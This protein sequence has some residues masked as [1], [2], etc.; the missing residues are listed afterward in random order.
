MFLHI[1]SLLSHM[2]PVM[3]TKSMQKKQPDP[4]FRI[5]SQNFYFYFINFIFFSG[6]V[7]IR[8]TFS[9]YSIHQIEKQPLT[10]SPLIKNKR[11]RPARV[12]FSYVLY[13]SENPRKSRRA[14]LEP[15]IFLAHI[16]ERQHLSQYG[17]VLAVHTSLPC[18]TNL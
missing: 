7:Q 11:E 18:S 10:I 9:L 14:G 6:H 12:S 4:L 1:C 5:S 8:F 13:L 3:P 16:S 15:Q 2:F 17:L